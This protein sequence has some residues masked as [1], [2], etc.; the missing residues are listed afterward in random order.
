MNGQR[1]VDPQC[2]PA[3]PSF[4]SVSSKTAALSHSDSF[5]HL[6]WSGPSVLSNEWDSIGGGD[7]FR[8][9][10]ESISTFLFF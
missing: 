5:L 2:L 10:K 9:K 6:E 3:G 8:G 7:L 4:L 1:I